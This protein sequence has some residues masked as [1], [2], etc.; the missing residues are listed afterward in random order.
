MLGGGP[1]APRLGP[2]APGLSLVGCGGQPRPWTPS[3]RRAAVGR[4][5][6]DSSTVLAA[7]PEKN[8]DFIFGR[9]PAP[10]TARVAPTHAHG[11][12]V[13]WSARDR[14]GGSTGLSVRPVSPSQWSKLK[15]LFR[16]GF[17]PDR[18]RTGRNGRDSLRER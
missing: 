2:V 9:A 10:V 7:R 17:A 13:M 3:H 4:S 5:P 8:G 1:T 18:R 12:R 6:F 14:S 16:H 15:T 11:P